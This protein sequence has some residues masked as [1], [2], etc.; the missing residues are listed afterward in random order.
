MRLRLLGLAFGLAW[1]II[2]GRAA[3]LQLLQGAHWRA[4]AEAQRTEHVVLAARRGTITERNG[5]P[6]AVTL[7]HYHV[8]LAPNEIGDRRRTQRLLQRHLGITAAEFAR[9]MRKRWSYFHG[10]YTSAQVDSIRDVGGVHLDRELRRFYPEPGF[11]R[12]VVGRAPADGAPASGLE[13]VLDTLLRGVAGEAVVLKDRGGRAYESPAR[14]RARPTPGAD[15]V[16][17]LDRA[18]QDIAQRGL[19]EARRETGAASGEVVILDPRTGELLAVAA[20]GGGG[21][22]GA[23]ALTGTFEPGS[24][25]KVFAAAALLEAGLVGEDEWVDGERGNWSLGYR[26]IRD[27]HPIPRVTLA[28]AIRHSSNIGIA[29]FIER[30]TP[31]QQ[32]V[33]LRAFGFGTLTGVESP[34][35][36][37]GRLR[38]PR[39][40]TRPSRHSLAIGYELAVTPLQLALAYGAIANDGVLQ[41]PSLVLEIREPDG[42][43]RARHQPRAVR[44]VISREVARTLRG[45][46][47]ETVTLGSASGG[48][49]AHFPVAGKTGT[50]RRVVEGSYRPGEYTASFVS[51][52]PADEPQLVLVVKLDSPRE[53]YLGGLTAAPVTR[54]MLEQA[55]A[56]RQVAMDRTRF[57]TGQAILPPPPPSGDGAVTHVVRWPWAP[58]SSED[59]TEQQSKSVVPRVAGQS[60]REAA[61]TLHRHGLRVRIDG[62]GVVR[63]TAP[64]AGTRVAPGSLVTVVASDGG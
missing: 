50:A 37:P 29:K 11:A 53:E 35:E 32:F 1:V 42:S 7:E 34:S 15:V 36:S 44:R 18:L 23:S 28:D 14:V 49:L 46:L 3:Q 27:V 43:V 39:E 57:A 31:E 19:A 4:K 41:Q 64:A 25:A 59:A 6:L 20:S 13:R 52:F 16:L 63:R 10:P 54:V 61:L 51:L 24:T 40:W 5:T 22:G 62:R 56:A 60:L 8:G 17:T 21:A 58:Q 45:W 55:L 30:L 48:A 12:G 47:A 26:V 38:L 2:L 9:A 33:M